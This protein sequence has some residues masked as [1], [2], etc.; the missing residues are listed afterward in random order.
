MSVELS[1]VKELAVDLYE[2]HPKLED[3]NQALKL[4]TIEREDRLEALKNQMEKLE[5][6]PRPLSV[7]S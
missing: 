4:A 1:V 3:A 6:T 5:R 2:Q 7:A